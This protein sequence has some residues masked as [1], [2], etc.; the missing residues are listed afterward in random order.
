MKMA[1][2]FLLLKY[3]KTDYREDIDVYSLRTNHIKCP[4]GEEAMFVNPLL[5]LYPSLSHSI[6]NPEQSEVIDDTP[7]STP[8]LA[9]LVFLFIMVCIFLFPNTSILILHIAYCNN[10]PQLLVCRDLPGEDSL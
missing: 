7:S 10:I 6:R 3:L 9:Y 1:A 8:A 5:A 2:A 4:F